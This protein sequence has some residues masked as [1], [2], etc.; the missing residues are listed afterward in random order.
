MT[1]VTHALLLTLVCGAV[2]L[3]IGVTIAAAIGWLRRA[4]R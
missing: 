2:L 3:S 4:N 1:T